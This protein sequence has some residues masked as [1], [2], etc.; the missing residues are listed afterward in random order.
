M[1]RNKT[2]FFK[3]LAFFDRLYEDWIVSTD[4]QPKSIV[5]FLDDHTALNEACR[6]TTQ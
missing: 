6:T 1:P 5:V 2:I 3:C 4:C